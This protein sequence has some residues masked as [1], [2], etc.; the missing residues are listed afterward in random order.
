VLVG[1][2]PIFL[3]KYWAK[4]LPGATPTFYLGLIDSSAS[5]IVMLLAP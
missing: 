3:G 4:D 1:F 2:F 5:F